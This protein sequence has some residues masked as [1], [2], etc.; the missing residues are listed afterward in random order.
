MLFKVTEPLTGKDASVVPDVLMPFEPLNPT[1]A[2][3][4]RLLLVS[5]KERPSDGYVI[6]G[7]L[8]NARWHEPITE[9]PKAGS[10]RTKYGRGI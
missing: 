10:I 2:T 6:T 7:L 5:E 8:G 3:R 1:Y 4:E 9:D